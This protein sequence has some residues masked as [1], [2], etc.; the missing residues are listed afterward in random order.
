MSQTLEQ[1][2]AAAVVYQNTVQPAQGSLIDNDEA[3]PVARIETVDARA[4]AA[5]TLAK[6]LEAQSFMAD[7]GTGPDEHFKLT[8]VSDVWPDVQ[9][10]LDYPTAS[11]IDF[12][13]HYYEE[14]SLVPTVLDETWNLFCPNT[15]LWKTSEAVLRFQVD[16]WAT[17]ENHRKGIAAR[18]PALFS[19]GEGRRGVIL[20]GDPCYYNRSVRATL[21]RQQRKDSEKTAFENERRIMT[22][23]Q[24]EIDVVQLRKAVALMPEIAIVDE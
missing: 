10:K 7:G 6:F 19:P 8:S 11:I 13:E 17:N 20:Q 24:C 21:L 14:H 4:A 15:V 2:D 22:V 18:L 23:I 16:F 3:F 5:L 1:A 9:K 12:G